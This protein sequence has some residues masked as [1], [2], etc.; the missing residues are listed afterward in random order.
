MQCN[1]LFQKISTPPPPWTTVNGV[2]K[3][4]I[5]SKKFNGSLC[6]IPNSADSKSWAI[7]E[8]RKI[9]NGFPGI[10]VRLAE[11]SIQDKTRRDETRRDPHTTHTHNTHTR[12]THTTHTHDTH[13]THDTRH[14]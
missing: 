1:G 10:I 14:T 12:H 5:I 11:H 8:F 9:L 2:P 6:R 4:F 7:P 3:N 13:D